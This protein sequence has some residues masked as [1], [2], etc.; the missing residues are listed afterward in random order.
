MKHAIRVI[1]LL[2]GLWGSPGLAVE[3]LNAAVAS[4]FRNTLELLADAWQESGGA[5]LRISSASTG[6]LYAQAL[7]GAPFDILLAA[8]DQR[9]AQLVAA[10]HAL[11]GSL[12]TY[13]YGRLVLAYQP[14]LAPPEG[15]QTENALRELL[16]RPGVQ[17]ALANPE[18]APYG[19]AAMEV[20]ARYS[21]QPA[22]R[23]LTA[24][25]V[26][27]AYQ[28]WHSG[29]AG[30]ALV[31]ASYAPA[32]A[33]DIPAAWHSPIAQQGVI[34]SASRQPELAQAFFEFL[35]SAAARDIIERQGY[36]VTAASP[37]NG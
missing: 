20:L 18:L 34:L 7:H 16:S 33:L 8:D 13:A 22:P 9:P 36:A 3:T 5:K 27:Q 10:G 30:L 24:P 25:N 19:S 35:S 23:I 12:V 29:G 2:S 32:T 1:A 28:M 26:G 11:A 37:D 31:A 14:A 15:L 21:T 6:V 4:N 17:L